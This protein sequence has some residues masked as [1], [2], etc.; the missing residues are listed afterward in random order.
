MNLCLAS[1]R[2]P[3]YF[4]ARSGEQKVVETFLGKR[5]SYLAGV[6]LTDAEVAE[7]KSIYEATT[8]MYIDLE[9]ARE[10]ATKLITFVHALVRHSINQNEEISDE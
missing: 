8:G 10:K 2:V 3:V 7:F 6:N 9:T 5:S 1:N 4:R